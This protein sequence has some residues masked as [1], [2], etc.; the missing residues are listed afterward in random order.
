MPELKLSGPL[1]NICNHI[2]K[3]DSNTVRVSQ[4]D[5]ARRVTLQSGAD[6][7]SAFLDTIQG[8]LMVELYSL[9]FSALDNFR[10]ANLNPTL[11]FS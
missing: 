7:S 1:A 9:L 10:F 6:V 11:G 5:T 8:N 4:H 3:S 2:A